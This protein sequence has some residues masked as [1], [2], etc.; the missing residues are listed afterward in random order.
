MPANGKCGEVLGIVI[1]RPCDKDNNMANGIQACDK[2]NEVMPELDTNPSA[3]IEGVLG[4][5][6]SKAPAVAAAVQ[7]AVAAQPVAVAGAVLPFTGGQA[8]TFLIA[9]FALILAGA[10]VLMFRRSEA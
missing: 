2:P 3:P 1:D 10:A 5:R 9:A 4:I 8:L 6:V 7:P